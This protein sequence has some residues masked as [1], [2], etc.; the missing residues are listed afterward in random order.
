MFLCCRLVS[1]DRLDVYPYPVDPR[2]AQQQQKEG[3]DQPPGAPPPQTPGGGT[4]PPVKI[5]ARLAHSSPSHMTVTQELF[6]TW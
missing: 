2:P 5:T 1:E 6:V 4:G 3:G